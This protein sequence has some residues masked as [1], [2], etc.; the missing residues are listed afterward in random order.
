MQVMTNQPRDNCG[1]PRWGLG[2]LSIFHFPSEKQTPKALGLVFASVRGQAKSNWS[3]KT[4]ARQPVTV[5]YCRSKRS[6]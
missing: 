6:R 3:K 4:A 2:I 5:G 1:T